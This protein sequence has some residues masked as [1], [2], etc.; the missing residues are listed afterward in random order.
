MRF[1]DRRS[2]L[3]VGSV[4][5]FGW[6]TLGDALAAGAKKDGISV[7][8][9]FLTGGMSQ[10]DTFDPKPDSKP[11]FRSKFASIPTS[12]PGFHVTEHLPRCAKLAHKYTTIRSMTHKTPVH[13]PAC[14]LI[15]SG[16]LPLSSITHPCVGS[17]V[18][19][20]LGQR[21]EMPSFVSVP[22][23]TGYWES[24][25]YIE[26]RFNPFDA[27]NPNTDNFQ[28]RDLD[29]PLGVDWAR[30]DRRRSLLSLADEKFRQYDSQ[31]V[32]ENMN[33]YYQTAFGLMQSP[34]AKKAFLIGEE[35]EKLREAYGRTSLGQ[36]AL[37]ARRLVQAGVRYVT[38]SRGF[39][40]WDH[41][42]NI[43]PQL[44]ETFLPELDN[45]FAT[46]LEDLEA[47]GMLE[48]TLVIVTGEFGRTPEINGNGG[49]DHW[50]NAFSMCMAGAGV[51]GGQ[52]WGETDENGAYVTKDPVE[53]PDF[54]ATIFE[55]LGINY[56]KE[57][58]NPLGRPT[59][60]SA[61]GAKPL[62]FLY[63]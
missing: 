21:N 61:D 58:V 60:L 44:T 36:G 37:L 34:R 35:T 54:T 46:L 30:M 57:Y 9:L 56:T 33:S 19:K 20:E 18:A 29:L 14:G 42:A 1:F 62:K 23:S 32:I 16:H 28:V 13:V 27:G 63:S 25:G 40:T 6:L 2:F 15:L 31:N 26:P 5:P 17:V 48:T 3:R 39:N 52:V 8:H 22:A 11:E 4:V 24:A 49:R 51:P 43:F 10:M 41:H 12:V 55:K 50:A 7:I 47:H 38:I 53:I 45:A 59:K